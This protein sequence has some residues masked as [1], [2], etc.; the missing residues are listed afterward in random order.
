MRSVMGKMGTL[1]LVVAGSM[2]LG[3]IESG[4]C[5][6]GDCPSV[7]WYVPLLG[8]AGGLLLRPRQPG[9]LVSLAI[10]AS[11][12]LPFLLVGGV[13]LAAVGDPD[14]ELFLLGALVLGVLGTLL[15]AVLAGVTLWIRHASV[16]S[17]GEPRPR[18][19]Q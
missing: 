18:E 17:H 8:L 12:V 2:T 13:Y 7:L 9:L 6:P 19:S 5:D 1:L 14:L 3:I 11:A 16:L 10:G 4:E 15:S